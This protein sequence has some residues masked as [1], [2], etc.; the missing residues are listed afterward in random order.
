[1]AKMVLRVV[2]GSRS[3]ASRLKA[4]LAVT[5]ALA[6]TCPETSSLTTVAPV[7]ASLGAQDLDGV[8]VLQ[9]LAAAGE[10]AEGQ[11]R[12]QQPRPGQGGPPA[13][14]GCPTVGPRLY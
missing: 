10:P 3:G 7:K 5:P 9:R 6:T 8:G 11:Q 1:M 2:L 14:A 12:G 4:L 13:G